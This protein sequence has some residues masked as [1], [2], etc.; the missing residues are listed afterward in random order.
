MWDLIWIEFH[1]G[2]RITSCRHVERLRYAPLQRLSPRA[3]FHSGLEEVCVHLPRF[4]RSPTV[5]GLGATGVSARGVSG[6]SH[7]RLVF[8]FFL[9]PRYEKTWASFRPLVSRSCKISFV[10]PR[11]CLCRLYTFVVP[12]RMVYFPCPWASEVQC[13]EFSKVAWGILIGDGFQFLWA[14]GHLFEAVSWIKQLSSS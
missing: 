7:L 11:L 1:A 8:L 6:C 12:A 14:A 2:C 13:R 10:F 5:T 9:E 3:N 4:L